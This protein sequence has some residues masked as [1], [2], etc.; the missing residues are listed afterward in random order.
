[1]P[2]LYVVRHAKAGERRTWRGDD[3]GRPLSKKGRKQSDMV[4][5]RLAKLAPSALL[6]SP[7]VRCIQTLEPLAERTGLTVEIDKR[8][9]EHEPVEPLLQLLAEVDA[10]T[11]VCSHGDLIPAL[12]RVLERSGTT[13]RTP[14]DWRKASIWVLKRN[15]RGQIVH[16]TV[17]PP[18][19]A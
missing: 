5:R 2:Q 4:G 14:V 8:L 16:A 15:K 1:M 10:D 13:L 12:L 18:P 11:V 17:W 6:S 19:I 7:Y 3:I 9:C